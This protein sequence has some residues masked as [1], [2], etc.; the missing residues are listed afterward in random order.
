[1][2]RKERRRAR[3]IRKRIVQFLFMTAVIL[4]MVVLG[5]IDNF[6]KNKKED[7]IDTGVSY[8][9]YYN[10]EK[11]G[12]IA[13]DKTDMKDGGSFIK[14]NTDPSSYTVLVNREYPM[15]EDYVPEDLVV[16]AVEFSYTGIYE[17]SYMRKVAADAIKD[18][19]EKAYTKKKYKLKVVSAYRSYSRQM[20]IYNNNVNTRGEEQTNQ[21]SAKPGCSEHQ[22]GLAIDISTDTVNCA[23]D[24]TFGESDEGKW[25]AKNCH[26]FGFIIRYPEGKSDIT[27]YSYESW[28]L[29]FVGV[30]LASYLYKNQLT[31]EEYYKTTTEDQKIPEEEYIQDNDELDN[32]EPEMTAAPTP[33]TTKYITEKETEKPEVVET[34]EPEIVTPKPVERPT[35]KPEKTPEIKETEK[36]KVTK[37]PKATPKP[38]EMPDKAEPAKTP[39]PVKEPAET[40]VPTTEPVQTEPASSPLPED[41]TQN[42]QTE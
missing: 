6:S 40:V 22:T 37:K 19:F 31:L 42:G 16:P 29:R 28:H 14:V 18:M 10:N 35:K 36:P 12:D 33:Q 34:E 8:G 21:V 41:E 30:N 20:A 27:G 13:G 3:I 2:T 24:N 39:A 4:F 5:E 1:M 17:K 25:V 15:P 32:D 26:K 9:E 7:K 11:D 23:I 38:S